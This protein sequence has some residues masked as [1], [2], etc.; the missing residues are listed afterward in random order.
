MLIFAAAVIFFVQGSKSIF[1]FIWKRTWYWS[2]SI[3]DIL[4]TRYTHTLEKCWLQWIHSRSWQYTVKEH[5]CCI[6]M[7]RRR[8]SHHIYLW[9][10]VLHIRQ[11]FTNKETR[12]GTLLLKTIFWIDISLKHLG[13]MGCNVCH[14]WTTI[15]NFCAVLSSQVSGTYSLFWVFQ[16]EYTP[17][18]S[19]Y[20]GETF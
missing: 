17:E 11:W 13:E 2:M 20:L 3:K 15:F 10:H 9:L 7:P 19:I 18:V 1:I 16:A 14:N 6:R 4:L 5:P 8:A 12:W